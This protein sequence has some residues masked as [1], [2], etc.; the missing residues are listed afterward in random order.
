M[1]CNPSARRI[2]VASWIA[3]RIF[4]PGEGRIRERPTDFSGPGR[5]FV[6]P[7]EVF[8]FSFLICSGFAASLRRLDGA[9]ARA[10][11][12]GPS[13][14]ESVQLAALHDWSKQ[15]KIGGAPTWISTLLKPSGR[16]LK[17]TR[18]IA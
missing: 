4:V 14:P 7:V 9:L 8:I 12:S 17:A 5:H 11:A 18:A 2:S 15:S 3:A 16:R 1:L 13:S 10:V 6:L